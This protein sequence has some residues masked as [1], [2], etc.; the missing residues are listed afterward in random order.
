MVTRGK[1]KGK[2]PRQRQATSEKKERKE[3]K[4][5][6]GRGEMGKRKK[7]KYERNEKETWGESRVRN[8]SRF[9]LGLYGRTVPFVADFIKKS[10]RGG[11]I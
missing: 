8:E 3:G 1:E 2:K 10:R 4:E 11:L 7:G 6:K 9:L 5:G